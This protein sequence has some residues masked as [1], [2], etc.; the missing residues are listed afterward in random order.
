MK[1]ETQPWVGGC[2]ESAGYKEGEWCKVGKGFPSN[3][4]WI[5]K[6]P[7]N[8]S[9]S[10]KILHSIC[11]SSG[12]SYEVKYKLWMWCSILMS[13][14]LISRTLFLLQVFSLCVPQELVPFW[15]LLASSSCALCC[16]QFS[17]EFKLM[18]EDNQ[19][20]RALFAEQ[21]RYASKLFMNW[22]VQP[23]CQQW[24]ERMCV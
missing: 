11:C 2:F 18:P 13:V 23:G 21:R 14:V 7:K 4:C 16:S 9:G 5:P 22:F 20:Q 19:E 17:G 3:S 10:G 24:P 8:C 1:A 12:P 15:C 6:C